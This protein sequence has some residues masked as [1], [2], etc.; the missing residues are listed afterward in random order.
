[1]KQSLP[2]HRIP[3]LGAPE[4]EGHAGLLHLAEFGGH[5][6]LVFQGRRHWYEG[7]GWTPVALPIYLL[8]KLNAQRCSSPTPLEVW[9]T[10]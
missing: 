10:V 8:R 2:Y 7:Y 5:N 1:V 4:V 6:F 3:G 9:G